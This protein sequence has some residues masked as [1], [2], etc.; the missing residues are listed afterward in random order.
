MNVMVATD[1]FCK[2]I[3]TPLGR[4]TAYVLSF[5]HLGSRKVFI[6]PS[7]YNPNGQ[8]MR[9]QAR[10]LSMWAEEEGI[11]VRFLLHDRDSKFTE[12]FDEY[13]RREDGGVVKTPYQSPIANCY[14]E[15]WIGSLKRENL[16]HFSV[17]VSDNWI[18]SFRLTPHTITSTVLI[19]GWVIDRWGVPEDLSLQAREIDTGRIR[20][21]QWLGGMLKH[22]YRQAA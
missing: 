7:T 11:D 14:I 18:I 3:W 20:C 12:A 9:Q 5:I 17:L 13:F 21:K 8:W 16:N 4:K 1:F 2:T 6:S 19:R 10:N 22:Y 15:S